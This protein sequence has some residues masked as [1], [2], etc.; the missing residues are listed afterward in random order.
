MEPKDEITFRLD[1]ERRD[2]LG[3]YAR[4]ERMTAGEALTA[5]LYFGNS[6]RSRR[7]SSAS[8]SRSCSGGSASGATAE[9][10]SV[11]CATNIGGCSSRQSGT[12]GVGCEDLTRVRGVLDRQ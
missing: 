6:G 12:G 3:A 11:P 9:A 5:L 10:G 1:D 8:R 2:R 4:R 7:P